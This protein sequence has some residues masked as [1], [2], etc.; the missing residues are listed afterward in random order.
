MDN[1]NNAIDNK[2]NEKNNTTNTEDVNFGEFA[3][4]LISVLIN[5]IIWI[6]LIGPIV[7]F[8]SKTAASG[9]LPTDIDEV[10]YTNQFLKTANKVINVNEV[11]EKNKIYSTKVLL[12]QKEVLGNFDNGFLGFLKEYKSNPKKANFFGNYWADIF[13]NINTSNFEFFEKIFSSLNN[14]LPESFII[15]FGP[16]ILG[17]LMIVLYLL[18]AILTFVYQI[19]KAR[20]F[21]AE[22]KI[23]N[24]KVIWKGS[25]FFNP[26]RWIFALLSL[27]IFWPAVF[28]VPIF[29]MF[30]SICSPLFIKGKLENG[31]SYSFMN[32]LIDNI[33][34]K[35]KLFLIMFSIFIASPIYKNLGPYYFV[36]FIIAVCILA[37]KHFYDQLVEPTDSNLTEGLVKP[38]TLLTGGYLKKAKKGNKKK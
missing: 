8:V 31:K 37:I 19:T 24:N 15:V 6:W 1:E 23:E 17:L 20:D 27:F 36:A 25:N 16:L 2:K 18:N 5:L 4:N 9:I 35:G 7:L 22:M 30:Y 29:T 12:N 21:F 34:Y 33:Y 38:G 28:M 13:F 3:L 11:K 26:I 32:F 10:P 14:T